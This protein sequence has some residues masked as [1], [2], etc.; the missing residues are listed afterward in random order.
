M[1]RQY[2]RNQLS[3]AAKTSQWLL[4]RPRWLPRRVSL[5]GFSSILT[6]ALWVGLGAS[7]GVV[8]FFFLYLFAIWT[9]TSASLNRRSENVH[10]E[11]SR[12]HS[13]APVESM[14]PAPK[15]VD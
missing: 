4:G 1:S 5:Q 15:I 13:H 10:I 9:F 7:L 8:A 14:T 2:Q 3:L 6:S 11:T 12:S